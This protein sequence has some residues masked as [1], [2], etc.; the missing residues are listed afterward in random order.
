MRAHLSCLVLLACVSACGDDP[1]AGSAACDNLDEG[2][3]LFPY[4]SDRFRTTSGGVA[5]LS[6]P[7]EAL[8]VSTAGRHVDPQHFQ[9][10]DGFSIVTPIL[11]S[12]ER[13]TLTGAVTK[14][15]IDA[16]LAA[17]S[18]TLILDA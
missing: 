9:R 12:L 1:P 15:D 18:K 13:A 10:Q 7:A 3:C 8:P 17:S 2:H 14:Q 4:P 6:F 16:S 11:F 5:S